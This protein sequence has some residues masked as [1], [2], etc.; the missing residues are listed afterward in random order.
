MSDQDATQLYFQEQARKTFMLLASSLSLW[1]DHARSLLFI[2]NM[3]WDYIDGGADPPDPALRM[4][5]F[6]SI[7]EM[8]SGQAIESMA[9][10]IRVRQDPSIVSESTWTLKSHNLVRLVEA[11]GL[12]VDAEERSVLHNLTAF[13][14]WAGKYPIPLTAEGL[15][16][17]A[18]PATDGQPSRLESPAGTVANTADRV[19]IARIME[20]LEVLATHAKGKAVEEERP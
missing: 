5:R 11:T 9:K 6:F 10:G 18:H 14:E 12:S 4:F 20:R 13:I 15:T 3:V 16:P 8:L 19:V 1:G 2:A 7:A 17:T